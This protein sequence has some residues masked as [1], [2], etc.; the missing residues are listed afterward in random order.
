MERLTS[1][2]VPHDIAGILLKLVLHVNKSN[3][4]I[5]SLY[6]SI[7]GFSNHEKNV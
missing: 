1:T 7:Q 5:K 3:Q 4:I 2:C 6:F